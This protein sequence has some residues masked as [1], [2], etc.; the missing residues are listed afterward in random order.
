MEF[1]IVA[2]LIV[3]QHRVCKLSNLMVVKPKHE[4]STQIAAKA[5][6]VTKV[7]QELQ[8]PERAGVA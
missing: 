2:W 1:K 5:A 7:T 8:G 6:E 3:R 4:G